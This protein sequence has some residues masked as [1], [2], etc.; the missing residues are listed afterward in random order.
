M[1]SVV[2]VL[3]QFISTF[4]IPLVIQSD[5]GSNFTFYIFEQILKQ[6]GLKHSCALA[7]HVQSQ[8]ALERFHRTLKSMLRIYG[9]E[10]G[11][12][13]EEGL[14]AYISSQRGCRG[15]YRV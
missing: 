1:K 5:Q 13:W 6:L 4:G 2:R 12:D 15:K 9:M 10:M 3:T 7:Y 8:G 11:K 14:M